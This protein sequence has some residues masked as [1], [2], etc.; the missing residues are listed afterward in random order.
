MS[1]CHDVAEHRPE[2]KSSSGG[3]TFKEIDAEL[4]TTNMLLAGITSNSSTFYSVINILAHKD[5]VQQTIIEEIERAV[6][7]GASVSLKDKHAMP[8]TRA[9]IYEV[10][11]YTSVAPLAVS[12]RAV[13]DVQIGGYTIPKDTRI[14]L[15]LWALHHDPEFWKD[16]EEFRPER[17]LDASGEVVPANHPNRKHLMP[18]GAGPRVCLGESLALTRL[19]IWTASMIQKFGIEPAH[20]N[21]VGL[22]DANNYVF[23]GNLSSQ[24]YQ[25]E[26]HCR[27]MATEETSIRL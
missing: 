16:P 20:G 14:Q 5:R 18:F 19:F 2:G 23:T 1:H 17:F 4:A 7:P 22:I 24:T 9:F 3:T 12:H 6:C 13:Q 21:N 15:N 25:V 10:L 26:F 8:Y 11:R 27:P